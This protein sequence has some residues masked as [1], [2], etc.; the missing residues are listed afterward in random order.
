MF[1]SFLLRILS[2][3]GKWRRCFC[4]KVNLNPNFIYSNEV[5]NAIENARPLVALESTIITHGLPYPQ[6]IEMALNVE[7]KIRE[8]VIFFLLLF[9]LDILFQIHFLF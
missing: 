6:N 2:N 9:E 1:S 5:Q 8:E 4:S 3:Y 7:K